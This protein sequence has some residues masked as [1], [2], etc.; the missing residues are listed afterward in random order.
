MWAERKSVAAV[1][2]KVERYF[3]IPDYLRQEQEHLSVAK[4]NGSVG[5]PGATGGITPRSHVKVASVPVT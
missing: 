4:T 2:V 1:L 3:G 5:S